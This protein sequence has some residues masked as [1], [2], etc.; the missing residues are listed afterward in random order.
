[1]ADIQRWEP[2]WV[3]RT[4]IGMTH[5]ET[6]RYVRYDDHVAA[7]AEAEQRVETVEIPNAW[8]AGW[9]QG[10]RDALAGKQFL[11]AEARQQ[12]LRDAVAAVEGLMDDT[13]DEGVLLQA[14]AAIK[15]VSDDR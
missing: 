8:N 1:M 6:G 13:A 15:A 14:I 7:V 9:R 3:T 4:S 12:A 11:V 10:Q 5:Y 2:Y